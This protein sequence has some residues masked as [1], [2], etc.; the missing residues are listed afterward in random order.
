MDSLCVPQTLVQEMVDHVQLNLPEE[1][2]GL[3]AGTAEVVEKV[4]PITNQ[5]HSPVRYYMD[6]VELLHALQWIEQAGFTLIGI[7]HSHP[8]GPPVPSETDIKEFLYPGTATVILAPSPDGWVM[9]AFDLKPESYE[10]I[11]LMI[12]RNDD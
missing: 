6:P 8:Q 11:K 12:N 1:A 2:C 9:N 4:I 5:A 3:L 7:F 10:K